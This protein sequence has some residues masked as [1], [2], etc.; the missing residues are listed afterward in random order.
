M[1]RSD[2]V[3]PSVTV[4]PL[5]V[6]SQRSVLR[7]RVLRLVALLAGAQRQDSNEE[8]RC[9]DPRKFGLHGCHLG[10]TKKGYGLL[11]PHPSTAYRR[12]KR[13]IGGP[14]ERLPP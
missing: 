8:D 2:P 4:F 5:E 1:P 13:P 9:R 12:G 10:K 11:R 14:P 7:Q 3:L 6:V